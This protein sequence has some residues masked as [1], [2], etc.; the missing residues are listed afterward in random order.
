MSEQATFPATT[1]PVNTSVQILAVVATL[2]TVFLA[3]LIIAICKAL[4]SIKQRVE[5]QSAQISS[6]LLLNNRNQL[7]AER[8]NDHDFILEHTT[9]IMAMLCENNGWSIENANTHNG[10]TVDNPN[11]HNG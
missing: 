8:L 4:K 9:K 1:F 11:F 5:L 6:L 7:H 3:S 10:N 2:M